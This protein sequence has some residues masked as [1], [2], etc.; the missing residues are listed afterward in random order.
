LDSW[1]QGKFHS[2]ADLFGKKTS[3]LRGQQ[4][5][6]VTF[7]HLPASIRMASPPLRMDRVV[8]GSGTVGF[9]GLEV[10]VGIHQECSG[11]FG[12]CNNKVSFI[13]FLTK[14]I[15]SYISQGCIK[16]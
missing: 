16:I 9:G 4:L 7:Q 11:V 15:C 14:A 5:R 13:Y 3:D 12:K 2:G 6:V 1:H 10:E 8:E